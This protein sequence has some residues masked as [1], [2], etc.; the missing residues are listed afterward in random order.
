MRG[1][2]LQPMRPRHMKSIGIAGVGFATAAFS[3]LQLAF[4]GI[5]VTGI[6]QNYGA[7]GSREHPHEVMF[8]DFVWVWNVFCVVPFVWLGLPF[9][10]QASFSRIRWMVAYACAYQ[11]FFGLVCMFF[12]ARFAGYIEMPSGIQAWPTFTHVY[13]KLSPTERLVYTPVLHFVERGYGML[14]LLLH[15]L[16]LATIATGIVYGLTKIYQRWRRSPAYGESAAEATP[17]PGSATNH[18]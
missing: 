7:V 10:K 4:L 11:V 14:A 17:D 9:L 5:A 12:A 15:S 6:L 3:W 18:V 13:S 8:S 2:G 1:Q 16:V